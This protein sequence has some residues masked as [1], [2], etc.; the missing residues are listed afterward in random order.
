MNERTLRIISIM[1]D[2][3]MNATQFAEAIGIQRA[4]MSHITG[5]RNNPSADVIA[6]IIERFP[7]VNPSWL[8]SGIG[9]MKATPDNQNSIHS[10]GDYNVNQTGSDSES[11]KAANKIANTGNQQ[12]LFYQYD[13]TPDTVA[14]SP[15]EDIRTEIH[16]S[17]QKRE[18]LGVKEL[19]N[20]DK[21]I[22]KEVVVYKERPVK[23]IDKILIFYSDNTYETFLPEKHDMK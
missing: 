8:L 4:A 2:E 17:D 15:E 12:D 22:D 13:K 9:S 7:N 19:K 3:N 10:A 18:G 21:S 14:N 16:F 5:G 6:K 1:N 23:T 20:V 11:A